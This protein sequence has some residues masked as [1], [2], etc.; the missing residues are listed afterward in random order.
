MAEDFP[1]TG[2]G[3]AD[4]DPDASQGA[5]RGDDKSSKKRRKQQK[6]AEKFRLE[7]EQLSSEER[8][9]LAR[10]AAIRGEIGRD[11]GFAGRKVSFTCSRG[12]VNVVNPATVLRDGLVSHSCRPGVF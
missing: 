11:V 9:A 8:A 1:S 7:L 6:R 10:H 12:A 3:G 5:D 2:N 4:I